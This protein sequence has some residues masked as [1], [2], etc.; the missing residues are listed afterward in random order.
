MIAALLLLTA[1]AVG[2]VVMVSTAMAV[3]GPELKQQAVNA[4]ADG[5]WTEHAA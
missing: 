1:L 4:R 2:I 3:F 5:R